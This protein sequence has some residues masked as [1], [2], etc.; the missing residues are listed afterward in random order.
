[1]YVKDKKIKKLQN[2]KANFLTNY[3]SKDE[4]D[5]FV[6]GELK[7]QRKSVKNKEI[8]CLIA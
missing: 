1:M 3:L 6:R 4:M 7:R 2:W 8:N 5:K